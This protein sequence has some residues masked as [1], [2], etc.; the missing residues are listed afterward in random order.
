MRQV[1]RVI[2]VSSRSKK[3]KP[4]SPESAGPKT[5]RSWSIRS[6]VSP[7]SCSNQDKERPAKKCTKVMDGNFYHDS[8]GLEMGRKV[9][10]MYIPFTFQHSR[11]GKEMPSPRKVVGCGGF[12][13]RVGHARACIVQ[14]KRS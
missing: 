7:A 3:T 13:Q 9:T 12:V 4:G 2:R 6:S 5:H 1:S 8:V 11:L 14:A 10:G